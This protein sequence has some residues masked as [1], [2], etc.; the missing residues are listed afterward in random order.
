[1]PAKSQEKPHTKRPATDQI[2][3]LVRKRLAEIATAE[4]VFE[5]GAEVVETYK[6]LY[7]EL[8]SYDPSVDLKAR[9][10]TFR[11]TLTGERPDLAVYDLL[12]MSKELLSLRKEQAGRMR[13]SERT[14]GTSTC[15]PI[16][17][18]LSPQSFTL[19]KRNEGSKAGKPHFLRIGA[20]PLLPQFFRP[21][22]T[23]YPT[24]PARQAKYQRCKLAGL[25][26]IC[27][28]PGNCNPRQ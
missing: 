13:M 8:S 24:K 17:R 25:P 10:I 1:M 5:A 2:E 3:I 15:I 14:T 22:P 11:Q 19:E 20:A 23:D 28:T 6:T 9:R 7:P 4:G 18:G 27:G 16:W 26:R 21:F 12:I